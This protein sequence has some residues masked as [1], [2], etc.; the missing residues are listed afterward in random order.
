MK[1]LIF[2]AL[3]LIGSSAIYAQNEARANQEPLT[4]KVA[5]DN[6]KSVDTDVSILMWTG[7]KVLGQHAGTLPL[8]SGALTFDANGN[9]TGG[10]IDIAMSEM[11]VTDLE[12]EMAA[13]LQGHLMSP[14]FFDTANHPQA[15]IK[16]TK[17]ISRGK[18]GEYKIIADLTIKGITKQI[19][20][21]AVTID[22]AGKLFFEADITI[23]RSEFDVQYGSGS[24]FEAL[25]D[26]TIYDE[27]DVKVI[28]AVQ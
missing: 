21:N 11:T 27:F 13:K 23:D 18:A 10:S 25:G 1:N 19:K 20:F 8:E 22:R 26:N 15:N 2:I 5:E 28:L 4:A 17:V 24:F 9:L 6:K 7:Y 12:G 16:I 3:L 14:D